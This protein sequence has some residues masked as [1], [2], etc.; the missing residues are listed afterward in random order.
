M[1][2]AFS[3]A[4]S[5]PRPRKTISSRSRETGTFRHRASTANSSSIALY[6]VQL[7]V[8]GR[9]PVLQRVKDGDTCC[10]TAPGAAIR[11]HETWRFASPTARTQQ[12]R[13]VLE[14]RLAS[15]RAAC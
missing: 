13:R 15:A 6:P 9:M 8:E 1:T 4:P 12:L 10:R 3:A 7:P 5:S 11:T 14:R 2:Q